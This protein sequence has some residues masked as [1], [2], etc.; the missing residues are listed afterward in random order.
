MRYQEQSE[1]AAILIDAP[2]LL[3]IDE[4]NKTTDATLADLEAAK[5]A[6]KHPEEKSSINGADRQVDGTEVFSSASLSPFVGRGRRR[7]SP[8]L[9]S[10]QRG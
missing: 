6:H 2:A 3:P 5:E 10:S 1:P 8:R 7:K 9:V 4:T